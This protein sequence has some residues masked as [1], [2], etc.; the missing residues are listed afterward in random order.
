[1]T[2]TISSV[3]T[4]ALNLNNNNPLPDQ[5]EQFFAVEM[6]FDSGTVRLWSGIGTKTINNNSFLG[7]GDLLGI[8]ETRESGDMTAHELTVSLDGL[9][10]GILTAALTEQYQGRRAKVLWGITTGNDAVEIFAGFMD[11]MTINDTT[12]R[13]QI[14]LTIES[15][16][17][18][19]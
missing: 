17:L 16:L 18:I 7:T 9:D 1:M 19:L 6:F 10:S 11:T 14:S 15:K 2:K 13:S 4:S 5:I 12:D 8:S 3:I